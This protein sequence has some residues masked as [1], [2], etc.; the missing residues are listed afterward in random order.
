VVVSFIRSPHGVQN[1]AL[2]LYLLDSTSEKSMWNLLLLIAAFAIVYAIA[3]LLTE[4]LTKN[5]DE[6]LHHPPWTW[7]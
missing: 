3:A 4:A 6:D 5:D 2:L 7:P 1:Q